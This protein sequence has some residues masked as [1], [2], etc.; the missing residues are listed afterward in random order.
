MAGVNPFVGY[1]QPFVGNKGFTL[2]ELIV[3]LTI[4][5]ILVAIAGPAMQ[6]FVTSNRLTS[7]VND[8]MAD[9]NITRNEAIKRATKDDT[10]ATICVSTNGT[11]CAVG[12]NWTNGWIVYIVCPT[13]YTEPD[14]PAGTNRVIKAHEALTSGNRLTVEQIV[15]ATSVASATDMVTYSRSGS[16]STATFRYRFTVCDPARRSSRIIDV[17]VLGQTAIS[18]GT[19]V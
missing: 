5:G 16:F 2:V 3:V 12:G 8:L 14:C 6:K 1:K 4:A 17:S 19:C 9:I 10:G 13:T 18:S 11:T 7:Q 15:A